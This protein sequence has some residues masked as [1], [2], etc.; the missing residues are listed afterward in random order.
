MQDPDAAAGWL[1]PG[2]AAVA[3]NP[4]LH[5]AHNL[6]LVLL[7]FLPSFSPSAHLSTHPLQFFQAIPGSGADIEVKERSGTPRI[8][9]HVPTYKHFL[10]LSAVYP[11]LLLCRRTLTEQTQPAPLGKHSIFYLNVKHGSC[12]LGVQLPAVAGW[13]DRRMDRGATAA[14]G[15]ATGPCAWRGYGAA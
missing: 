6:F 5:I 1:H 8:L 10:K 12:S 13:M 15:L 11:V 4:R 3:H 14:P 2:H 9:I 7:V